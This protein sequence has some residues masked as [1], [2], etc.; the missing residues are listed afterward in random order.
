MK[1]VLSFIIVAAILLC[2]FYGCE[3]RS[4]VSENTTERPED[5]TNSDVSGV[6]SE[7]SVAND[8]ESVAAAVDISDFYQFQEGI[9]LKE[10]FE[11]NSA[12]GWRLDSDW[13]KKDEDGQHFLEGVGHQW[14][15][16]E[17]ATTWSDYNLSFDFKLNGESHICFRYNQVDGGSIRYYIMLYPDSIGIGKQNGNDFETLYTSQEKIPQDV[18]QRL[19]VD[20]NSNTFKLYLDD[21]LLINLTDR[22]NPIDAGG[23]AFESLDNST[24]C[25]DNIEV[26]G[27]YSTQRNAWAK[28]GGPLGGLGYDVRIDPE[29]KDIMFVTDNPSGVNKSI[30]GG[31][32]WLQ[33]NSGITVR[34]G[35]SSDDIPIFAL[36]IDPN[37]PNIV[38]TGTQ[39]ARGI[40]RS[41]DCGETWTKMDNGVVEDNEITFRG[42]AVKPGNSDIVFAA[43]EVDVGL[44]GI[45]FARQKG[46]IYKTTDGGKNWRCVWEGGSLA[47]I[48]IFDPVDPEIMYAS[49]GIFDREAY[50]ETGEGVLKSID[51][52]ETW[53]NINNGLGN[54]YVGFL[55]MHPTD[56]NTLICAAGNNTYQDGLGIYITYDGGDN[57]EKILSSDSGE[58]FTVVTYSPSNPKIIYAGAPY[59]F[60][61]TDNGGKTWKKFSKEGNSYGSPGVRAGFP[62]SAVVDPDDPMVIYVNNYGGGVFKST[63]GAKTWIESSSGYTGANLHQI[64]VSPTDANTIF[65]VGRS[66]PYVSYDG[67]KSWA[68]MAYPPMADAEWDDISVCPSNSKVLLC[69]DEFMGKMY[70]SSDGGQTWQAVV[71]PGQIV[72]ESDDVSNRNGFKAIEFALSNS[73]VV[74]AG[75][76]KDRNAIDGGTYMGPSYGI[77]KSVDGGI[78]WAE[79]NSGLEDTSKNINCIAIHPTDENIVYIGTYQDGVFK[80][81][82]GGGSWHAASNGLM[83]EDVRSLAIDPANP[84]IVYAG[85]GNGVGLYKTEDGGQSWYATSNGIVVECPSYLQRIGQVNPGISLEKPNRTVGIDYASTPWTLISSVVIYP[86]DTDIIFVS[87][88]QRGIY[89][90]TTGGKSWVSINEGLEYK[91]VT[92]LALSGDGRVLYASTSGNGVYRLELSGE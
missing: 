62:I 27:E 12:D 91:A 5:S 17:S 84:D 63:D 86:G 26:N 51:G 16:Y 37:N 56:R 55:E 41:A 4:S 71:V 79:I 14:A 25:I 40:F 53:T 54:L 28:T 48:V 29:N 1:K 78:T 87:D 8:S 77:F 3:F 66:G 58:P 30:N 72:K 35:S 67:G 70:R 44:F 36:T 46:K 20:A 74:Y 21:E 90:T 57:W 89:M 60:F 47:R 9:L 43:A 69:S 82:D 18:W 75:M 23:I 19:S 83:S 64:V 50:N 85:L 73:D 42:F 33:T 49:T 61:R 81:E 52:G 88:Y 38:W 6:D 24:L 11:N 32:T 22:G 65:V 68:G 80:S 34:T 31:Q 2:S 76:R 13:S 59:A 10:N 7:T 15:V 92:S 45:E 39:T